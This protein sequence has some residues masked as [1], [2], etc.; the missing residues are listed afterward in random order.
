M[1]CHFVYRHLFCSHLIYKAGHFMLLNKEMCHLVYSLFSQTTLSYKR[2]L[3]SNVLALGYPY[4]GEG[5]VHLNSWTNK[6]RLA[7]FLL[8]FF[9]KQATL[10]RRSTVLSLSL[11]LDFPDST[12][13]CR[14]GDSRPVEDQLLI[15]EMFVDQMTVDK[16]YV[17]EISMD[18][19]SVNKLSIDEAFV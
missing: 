2:H 8:I 5:S 16:T 9:S 4:W 18:N 13:A 11:Q 6:Y 15:Q 10:I 12:T 19:L 3:T 1:S 14:R 7:V 17:D